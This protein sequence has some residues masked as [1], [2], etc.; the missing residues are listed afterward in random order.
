MR[1]FKKNDESEEFEE[2]TIEPNDLIVYWFNE[3]GLLRIR[4]FRK[5]PDSE[6]YRNLFFENDVGSMGDY[7]QFLLQVDADNEFI[8]MKRLVEWAN[9]Q[10]AFIANQ[11]DFPRL[12]A[13]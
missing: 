2:T 4:I 12:I 8:I 7:Y 3:I 13:S 1:V 11:K 5:K 6:E 9:R 10:Q